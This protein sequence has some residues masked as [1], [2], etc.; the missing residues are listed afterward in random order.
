MTEA[1]LPRPYVPPRQAWNNDNRS[2]SPLG[3]N[4]PRQT[5]AIA[6]PVSPLTP[7]HRRQT[8]GDYYE[9]ADPRFVTELPGTEAQPQHIPPPINTRLP[10][11]LA[12]GPPGMQRNMGGGGDAY[13]QPQMS[14]SMSGE[15]AYNS[16]YEDIA[17]GS[18][19]PAESERST[20]T[21]V[22]QRGV[23]PRWNP[24][25]GPGGFGPGPG[26]NGSG[27]G[28]GG[29]RRGPP[30]QQRNEVLLSSNPDF[31]LPGMG[32]RRGGGRGGMPRGAG[33][34]MPRGG[35][36]MVPRSAYDGGVM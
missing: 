2:G 7:T 28:M 32:P 9:D 13:L 27:I 16:S 21:S 29:Q 8:S 15:L 5:G 20:F 26:Q 10:P 19:S 1:N 3:Q 23:N 11:S 36:A 18:R 30:P 14:N 25:M 4:G 17:S 24:G 22:S 31:E 35:N 33:G 12:A 6:G 34:M